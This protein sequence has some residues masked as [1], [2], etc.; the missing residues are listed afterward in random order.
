MKKLATTFT[1]HGVLQVKKKCFSCFDFL[2]KE[3]KR[4]LHSVFA[5]LKIVNVLYVSL[6]ELKNEFLF[7]KGVWKLERAF[8]ISWKDKAEIP[9]RV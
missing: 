1:H 9:E 8:Q 3:I 2:F 6:R 5:G 7:N 4:F